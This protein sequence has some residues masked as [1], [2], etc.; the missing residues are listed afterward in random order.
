MSPTGDPA[1]HRNGFEKG[2][3]NGFNSYMKALKTAGPDYVRFAPWW[4]AIA[5]P[6]PPPNVPSDQMMITLGFPRVWLFATV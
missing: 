3:M 4:V 6:F 1:A 2:N 5:H